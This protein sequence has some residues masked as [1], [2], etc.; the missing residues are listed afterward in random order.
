MRKN[1]ILIVTEG[2]KLKGGGALPEGEPTNKQR[3]NKKF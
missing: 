2:G 1:E 3:G